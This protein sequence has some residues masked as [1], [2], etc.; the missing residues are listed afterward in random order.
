MPIDRGRL[1]QLHYRFAPIFFFPVLLTVLTGCLFQIAVL[2]GQGDTFSWL[3]AWHRGQ[4]GRINL[5]VVYPFFNAF[6]TLMLAITGVLLWF[7]TRP[8]Q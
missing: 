5:E 2:S 1:R 4:F 8:R 7:Q 3:L 6:G